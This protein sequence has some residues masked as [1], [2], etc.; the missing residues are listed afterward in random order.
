ME[1]I[2]H[3]RKMESKRCAKD[4]LRA[5][6]QA[7][8]YL[9]EVTSF[10]GEIPPTRAEFDAVAFEMRELRNEYLQMRALV[11]A[12]F[13]GKPCPQQLFAPWASTCSIFKWRHA[14]SEPLQVEILNGRIMVTPENFFAALRRHGKAQS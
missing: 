8:A 13:E 2:N 11:L 1:S 10:R 9:A 4:A 5:L 12:F 3:D 7:R 6:D 14:P